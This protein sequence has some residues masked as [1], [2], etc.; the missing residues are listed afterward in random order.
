M[1][2]VVP[3]VRF[4]I[5]HRTAYRYSAE[6]SSSQSVVHLFPRATPSQRVIDAELSSAPTETERHEYTDAFGNT[7]VY[8]SLDVPHLEW[9]VEA[10]S[11]VEV[12]PVPPPALDVGWETVA[13]GVR[14]AA[15]GPDV[16]DMALASTDVPVAP[17]LAG[18]ASD[19]FPPGGGLVEGVRS[20]TRRI[21][22][23]FSFDTAATE[24]STPVL[25][26]LEQ[27]RGVCQD[28]AHLAIGALRSLGL[29]ARYVSGYLET[30]PPPGTPKLVGADA[31]H[32]WLS[33]FV[34][35]VGWVDADPTNGYLPEDRH[36]T[37]AW[38]RDY[39]DVAPARGV[40][41]GPPSTQEL[42]VS[43]DVVRVPVM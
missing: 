33:V 38:G 29:A 20:L 17:E 9:I 22:E 11:T 28:F 19:A 26:V 23:E 34:P 8:L 24:V 5:A 18:F 15:Y 3:G 4:A 27:R 1:S 41:F 10:R 31:S 16:V 40:V 2:T 36:I 35:G 13:T 21:Y 30:D 43:V 6:V 37:V 14:S 25:T 39:T 32:A 12:L 7:A 42:E